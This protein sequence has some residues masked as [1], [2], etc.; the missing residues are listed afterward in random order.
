MIVVH[1]KSST[2][3]KNTKSTSKVVDKAKVEN[4]GGDRPKL[5][6]NHKKMMEKMY[7]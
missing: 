5:T 6:I 7:S 4:K 3:A 1:K 2:K